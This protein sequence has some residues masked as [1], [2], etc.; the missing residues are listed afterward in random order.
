M[1]F[2]VSSFADTRYKINT[3]RN[4]GD[5]DARNTKKKLI[6]FAS[7]SASMQ[8]SGIGRND[9]GIRNGSWFHSLHFIRLLA[10]L[11]FFFPLSRTFSLSL[12]FRLCFV[13]RI[14]MNE[15]EH[16]HGWRWPQTHERHRQTSEKPYVNCIHGVVWNCRVRA[17]SGERSQANRYKSEMNETKR[18]RKINL[19]NYCPTFFPQ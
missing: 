2:Q 12:L 4:K 15:L 5:R 9:N 14:M 17:V 19:W 3:P 13:C 18:N 16:E 7:S 11:S 8:L 6:V 1:R 10:V